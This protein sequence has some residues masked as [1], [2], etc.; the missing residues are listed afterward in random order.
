M[1]RPTDP[2]A[3]MLP[4]EDALAR[5]LA[6]CAP[7]APETKPP[8][9]AGG[10]VLA[11]D[12]VAPFDLPPADN[13]AMDGY[14][15][16]AAD[17]H[18]ATPQTPIPLKVIGQLPAGSLYNGP[19]LAAGQA[20]RIMT[21]APIP[22]GADAVVPFEETA[23]P[24]RDPA[25]PMPATVQ[26]RKAADGG[27]NVRRRGDD[28]VSGET[29]LRTGMRLGPAQIAVLASLGMARMQ[30]IRRPRVAILATGDELVPVGQPL[31]PGKI[32]DSN[33]AGVAA[34]VREFGGDPVR[35]GIARDT[36]D[37]VR[38]KLRAALPTADL[39]VT[40]AGVSRGDYDVVK[41]ALVREGAIQFWTVRMRPGKPLAFGTFSV[42]D[43]RT[44]PHLGL[45]GNPVSSL[46]VF[47]LFGR[48]A[49]HTLL[50]RPPSPRRSVRA[51]LH[52][53]IQNQDGRRVYARVSATQDAQGDWHARFAGGQ[54]SHVL[55]AL[56]AANGLAV[57]PE[58]VAAIEAGETCEV[59]LLE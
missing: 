39:I 58:D 51:V 35:L 5:V 32:Y 13:T 49:I 8:D 34:Q 18:G 3:G 22:P 57:C 25:A 45:P 50:G 21:G 53:R 1:P 12:V 2:P 16:R 23:E 43:G 4:V 26:I 7:L 9:A 44:V 54:G 31:P 28:V 24:D 40:S 14:A 10:Q 6:L 38:T 42:P 46:V 37:D 55:S 41:E 20:L 17:T 52:D 27:A 15:V 19:A 11:Q 56:A 29:I 33:T 30:V 59:I 36:L 48:A 47:E